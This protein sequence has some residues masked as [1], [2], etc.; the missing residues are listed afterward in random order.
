[1]NEK[2]A[3]TLKP[4]LEKQLTTTIALQDFMER[5]YATLNTAKAL[6]LDDIIQKKQQVIDDL[7]DLNNNW[8]RLLVA[9]QVDISEQSIRLF[10]AKLDPDGTSGLVT[11]WNA[12][13]EHTKAC[14]RLNTVNG[15]VIVLR[16]HATQQALD[17]LQGKSHS[18]T[19]GPKGQKLSNNYGGHSI[20]TV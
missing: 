15:S 19:Y 9:S 11:S 12:L 3:K 6:E 1:M 7:D 14:Q 13:C 8:Q 10:L 5:E 4:L 20:A 18:N 16:Q 2:F 17:I